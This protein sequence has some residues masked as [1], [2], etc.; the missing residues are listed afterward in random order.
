MTPVAL[1]L[2]LAAV[3]AVTTSFAHAL[4]KAG[5][6]KL[7][8][9]AWVRLTG[10]AF[11]L[12]LAAWIG[13]PPPNLWPWLIA[14]GL[15]HAVYQ[16][17]LIHSYSLSD[18]SVAYPIARGATPIF[19]AALGIGLLGD[20]LSPL[21]LGGVFIV[22][23][24]ILSLSWGG[25]IS[26]RGFA[27]AAFAGLL[28]TAYSLVDAKGVRLAPMAS[29]FIIWFYLADG[30]SMP[31]L[32]IARDK[33]QFPKALA[34]NWRTGLA[35]GIAALAAFVPAL[36]AFDLA[37]VGAVAAIRESSVIISLAI[38][39]L[40]LKETVDAKRAGGALLVAAGT[41][42]IIAGST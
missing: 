11:A 20:R 19:T 35:A 38:A 9:Q 10:L 31:L 5:G 13:L 8:V 21:V 23:L 29:T 12:P 16:Y 3:S 36:F 37:P 4:L 15:I 27:A 32:L 2:L 33:A 39:A 42:A 30:V 26:L 40:L 22:S 17:V 25:S 18:F 41:L 28:T 24:G 1:G 14:A 34:A 7:A 6:D